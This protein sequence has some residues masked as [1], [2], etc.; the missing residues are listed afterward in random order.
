MPRTTS[1][2]AA[3]LAV[4]V[5][6]AGC[7]SSGKGSTTGVGSLTTLS[8]GAAQTINQRYQSAVQPANTALSEAVNQAEQLVTGSKANA[9][10]FVPSTQSALNKAVKSLTDIGGPSTLKVDLNGVAAAMTAVIGDL[11]AVS[12][13]SGSGLAMAISKLVADS[14]KVSAAENVAQ[15]DVS[16]LSQELA[17]QAPLLPAPTTTVPLSTTTLHGSHRTTTTS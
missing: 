6:V 14:G 10:S 9:A 8:Q 1:L 15:L 17:P 4:A 16:Q 13:A 11:T 3:L 5:V 7:S 2:T 12:T